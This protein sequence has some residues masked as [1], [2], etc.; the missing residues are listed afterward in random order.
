MSI[1]GPSVLDSIQ[2]LEDNVALFLLVL[3]SLLGGTSSAFLPDRWHSE[4]V[5]A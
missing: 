2:G 5:N 4:V 3:V 1:F